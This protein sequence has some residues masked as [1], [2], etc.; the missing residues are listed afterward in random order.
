MTEQS[1]GTYRFPVSI[2]TV[3][4]DRS[5]RWLAK[6]WQDVWR[7][8]AISLAYG[9]SFVVLSYAFTFGL[10][11]L[12]LGALVPPLIG[13]FVLVSPILVVGLYEVARRLGAGEPVG[14]GAICLVCMR[15]A[16]Q[17]AAMGVVMLIFAFFWVVVANVLFALFFSSGVPPLEGL[18]YEMLF[19]LKGA[20]FLGLGTIFGAVLATVIF[21]ISAVSIPLLLDHPEIDVVTAIAT[22]FLAVRANWRTMFG[23]AALIGVISA[24][25]LATF[26]V[27]LAVALPMLAYA[28]W[29]AYTDLV[30]VVRPVD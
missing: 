25:G 18:V 30:E 3:P 24:V 28:S 29:H 22:S 4:V 19:T 6:G 23:W 11:E 27:G 2:R 12:E 9:F 16:G 17:V 14:F 15:N 1:G 5:G 10:I 13:A 20:A 26:Y 8:P 21:T 7:A